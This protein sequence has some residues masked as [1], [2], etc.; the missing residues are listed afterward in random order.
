[1]SQDSRTKIL[2]IVQLPPPV[3][4]SATISKVFVESAVINASFNI[5]VIPLHFSK[6]MSEI[7]SFSGS[8][9]FKTIGYAF[10][11]FQRL[12]SFKPDLVYFT[13]APIGLS[14]YRDI[15]YVIILR[16][17]GVKIAY[18]LHVRGI[19]EESKWRIKKLLYKFVF[20]NTYIITLS[21]HL[22]KD[23][24]SV[25]ER[26]PFVVNNGIPLVTTD[27]ALVKDSASETV[28]L[29][30]LSNFARSKGVFVLLKA[31][32]L[33]HRKGRR[34]T[35]SIVGNPADVTK[36]EIER[37]VSENGLSQLVTVEDAKYGQEKYVAFMN[38]DIF[39]HPTL[40]DAFPLVILEAMQFQLPVISTFEGAIPEIV[41]HER[42]G[43][44]VAKG[45]GDELH[46]KIEYLMLNPQ[47]MEAMGRAGRNKFLSTYT[48]DI[49]EVN[50]RNVL[51]H[52]CEFR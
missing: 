38:A 11:I 37:F 8:K 18:H 21:K 46:K 12:R 45:D 23:L 16:M 40:N 48:A 31:L 32:S 4:G 9:I 24:T 51:E 5:S 20:R 17:S 14:F 15:F 26:E 33:L 52:I 1:M 22:K 29:L 19:Q 27:A 35:A 47:I 36:E 50:L 6:V 25:Y 43:F 10:E 44:L 39:I 34:F 13:V 42:T 7:G 2:F 3:H 30:Y 49:M 41:D 28:K